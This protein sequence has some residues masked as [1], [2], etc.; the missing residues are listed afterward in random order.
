MRLRCLKNIAK[1]TYVGCPAMLRITL[2]PDNTRYGC[3]VQHAIARGNN[4]DHLSGVTDIALFT[5]QAPQ[6]KA[7]D[8]VAVCGQVLS[9]NSTN[10]SF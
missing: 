8:E 1:P 4:V 3:E 10:Q 5:G 7:F 2:S 9:D 6:V